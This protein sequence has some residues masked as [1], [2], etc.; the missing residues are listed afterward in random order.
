M[1]P[2]LTIATVR[3]EVKKLGF[4]LRHTDGEFRLN[5]PRGPEETAYFTNDR[6]DVLGTARDWARRL[7]AAH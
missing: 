2:K 7:A 4:N 5:T 6:D 1:R 3:A